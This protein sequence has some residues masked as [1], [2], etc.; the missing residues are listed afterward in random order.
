MDAARLAGDR[1]GA[2]VS[3]GSMA[4][5]SLTQPW[6]TLVAMGMKRIETRS[7]KTNYRGTIAIH[8]AKGFPKKAQLF[9]SY[10]HTMGRL[11][12]RI[13]RGAII[14]LA[15]IANCIPVEEAVLD[16]TALERTYGDYTYGV[17][18]WAWLLEDVV[19]LDEPLP[20]RGA[21]GLFSL[22]ESIIAEL[23]R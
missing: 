16:T 21:L 18:R 9:A 20:C 15:R 1:E 13:P 17:G 8:A 23:L 19:A 11:P 12:G 22:P 3:G 5:L 7:W 2:E 14:A 10:E 4:G 6:A